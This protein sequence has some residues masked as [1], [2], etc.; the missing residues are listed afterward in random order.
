MPSLVISQV[1]FV[2]M[3]MG[4]GIIGTFIMPFMP[5]CIIMGIG[6]MPFIICMGDMGIGIMPFIIDMGIGMDIPFIIIGIIELF[7]IGIA[8][9]TSPPSSMASREIPAEIHIP[10]PRS[11]QGSRQH[12]GGL[13]RSIGGSSAGTKWR[14]EWALLRR[15][16]T[17][18]RGAASEDTTNGRTTLL[19]S[20]S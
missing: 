11:Q 7:I 12:F 20:A 6:I 19:G 10:P 16:C 5:W 15:I 14:G 8:F 18:R 17:A 3:G 13:L 9:I 2:I 4:I 1:I